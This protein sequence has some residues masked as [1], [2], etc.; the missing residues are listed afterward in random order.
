[1][2]L[3]T[4]RPDDP[5]PAEGNIFLDLLAGSEI[6]WVTPQQYRDRETVFQEQADR[7]RSLGRKP[8]LIP[9]GGSTPLGS[10]GYVASM[11]EILGDLE[12]LGCQ[13]LGDTTVISAMGSG[14]TSSGLLL[15][16]RLLGS[17]I[18]VA[19]VN[20]CDDREYFRARTAGICAGF[21]AG[22]APD[23]P[24]DIH[25]ELDIVDGYVG[26]GYALSRPEELKAIHDLARM[27]GVVLDPVY[28]GKAWYGMVGELEKD[29]RRFGSRI[30]FVHTG[31]L[32]GLFPVA[33]QFRDQVF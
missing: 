33:G 6:V 20:V 11:E 30:V 28:T 18:R 25:G 23:L 3:R 7:L 22:Y 2:L 17:D 29:P 26:R 1:L 8:Y 9:E 27:E 12:D 15:G 4:D 32:F 16:A 24:A 31:G 5:P 21:I 19:A 10:W 13:D 14:G